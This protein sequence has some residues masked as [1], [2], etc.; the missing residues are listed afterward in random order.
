MAEILDQDVHALNE[1]LRSAWRYLAQPS[2]TRFQRREMRNQMKQA[3]H[4]LR[5]ALEQK[6]TREQARNS[7]LRLTRPPPKKPD[8]R[9][10]TLKA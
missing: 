4:A 8:F 10:L 5:I 2:L 3:E 6:S 7:E 1:W 9:L